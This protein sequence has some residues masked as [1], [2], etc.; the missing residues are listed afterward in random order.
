[1]KL[2]I[3]PG[4]GGK[5]PGATG[6]ALVEKTLNLAVA[7]AMEAQLQRS[8][9]DVMLSRYV[10]EDVT[11]QQRTDRANAW[12]ADIFLSIH[13]NG[14]SDSTA[15]GI[16][17]YYSTRPGECKQLADTVQKALCATFSM[18]NRGVKTK[19]NSAGMDWYHVLRE[20]RASVAVITESGFVTSPADAELLKQ[21]DFPRRQAEAL[22]GAIKALCGR[23][24]VTEIEKLQ[25]QVNELTN[26]VDNVY[27]FLENLN[28]IIPLKY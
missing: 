19:L 28:K 22:A 27:K 20:S 6:N 3:D 9:I 17:T 13:H 12:G 1:M 10:D 21:P 14:F 11:L 5:D 2:F 16:E 24:A 18:P 15:R 23:Q 26:R 4:H 8:G 25:L 7:L